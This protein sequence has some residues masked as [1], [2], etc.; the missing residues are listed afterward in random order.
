LSKSNNKIAFDLFSPTDY[1]YFVGDLLPYLSEEGYIKYKAKVE[2]ALAIQLSREGICTKSVAREISR[3]CKEV[4]AKEVYLEEMRIKHDIRALANVIRRKVS[5]KSKPYVHLTATSYDIVDTANALR[6]KDALR[7]VVLPD[8]ITLEQALIR[9]SRLHSGS[10]QIGRTHGQHAEPITFG[11]F[12]SF[13]VSRLG[14]R[15]LKIK[16][17]SECLTG[18]F[19]GAVGVYGPL[20]LLV[21]NPER[22]ER[23][24]LASLGLDASEVSTQIVQ[25]EA[26]TDLI[27]SIVSTFSVLA[28]FARDLRNLQRSEI[29]EVSEEFGSKQVGSSTMPQK[30]NPI[31]FENLESLWKKFMPQMV[32]VYMDQISDHQ[33]DLTNSSSQRYLPE[34]IVVFDYCVKRLTRTLWDKDTDRPKLSV[35]RDRMRRNLEYSLDTVAAEPLYVLLAV[36]GHPDAHEYVRQVVQESIKSGVPFRK[37]VSSK[38]EL[39]KYIRAIGDKI[40]FVENPELY[41]GKAPSKTLSVAKKWESELTKIT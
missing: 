6:F 14:K 8:L 20:S 25:P 12:L 31:S 23:E 37:V 19:A 5:N 21:G 40:K 33:R 27:H 32:T 7:N 15:I 34:L 4:S 24:L 16:E 3:A 10:I 38:P 13:Y 29:D 17:F 18:K 41:V 11:F 22:F 2:A 39:K 28:N 26:V 35:N 1:R 36:S 30:R 9:I